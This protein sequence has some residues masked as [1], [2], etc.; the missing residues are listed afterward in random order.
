MLALVQIKLPPYWTPFLTLSIF[1]SL[2]TIGQRVVYETGRKMHPDT[3]A[4]DMPS[5]RARHILLALGV[6]FFG[7]CATVVYFVVL[8]GQAVDD[9]EPFS[10]LFLAATLVGM[11]LGFIIY[12]AKRRLNTVISLAALCAF[13]VVMLV[14]PYHTGLV[15]LADQAMKPVY[16]LF[17]FYFRRY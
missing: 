13:Y 4:H 2:V 10:S 11:P 14:I 8:G 1:V 6:Q 16:S 17:P 15:T 5:I 3:M 12:A 9:L 7:V